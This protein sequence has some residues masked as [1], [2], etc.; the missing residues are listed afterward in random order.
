M[1]HEKLQIIRATFK[2]LRTVLRMFAKSEQG[3]KGITFAVMLVMLMVGINGLNVINSYVG[4]DF[5]SA[6]EHRDMDVFRHQALMYVGVFLAST[7][8]VVFYRFTEERLG[9]LWREQLTRKLTDAYLNDRTYYRLDSA[10][11]VA[12]PDQRISDDVRAF[13]TT[14]L[15]F[16]LLI[17]NG[18]LTAISFSS[19]LWSISPFLFCVA[20]TYALCGSALTIVLGRPLIRLNYNQLDMEANFRSDLIHVRE[21][22]E[23]IA[24]AH[25]E[26]R[27]KARLN[28]R[29]DALTTNFRQLIRINRNLGFF[30]NGYNYFIQI[31]PALIIAPMFI[32]GEKEF[33][34]IT[35]STMAFATL[36]GAFSLIVTQFQSISAFTAVTARLHTLSDAIEKANRTTPCTIT[37]EE[38]PDR[39]AYQNVTLR[40]GD[41][42]R[43]LVEDLNLEIPRGSRWLVIGKEDAPK[44]ALFRATAG[45]WECG[46]GQII[47]PGLDDILFLPERPY[48]PPGTLREVLLRT[49]AESVVPDAVIMGVIVKLGLEEVVA[50]AHGLDTDQDWDD[51]LSIGEQHLLSVSRIFL[52][53]PAFVFLDR[54]GSALPKN[55]I[56]SILEML[57]EQG[58]GVVILSK[59]GESR[60]RYDAILELK[61]AGTWEVRHET[62]L[63]ANGE[64]HDLSC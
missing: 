61:E 44:V 54:P 45:V 23:S 17:V 16:T 9:I 60:L 1:P 27:F 59:N 41:Q 53:K 34:V 19:V 40:S 52:A 35:Q 29:L 50:R 47:R 42:T 5:M 14:T 3:P 6:I 58:I 24:L 51:L 62:P 33:G 64:L 13:T 46:G 48:L 21:N 32:W 55:Q 39:V 22:S 2:R 37:V 15:S 38:S 31:I 26:G 56:S 28:R 30:T 11:G 36:L 4:R 18:T 7:L 25:R 10:T 63:D 8:V 43:V 12:N 49:G 20:V 57:T